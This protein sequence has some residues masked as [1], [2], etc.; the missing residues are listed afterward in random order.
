MICHESDSNVT[1]VTS[2][3]HAEDQE[4]MLIV[5]AFSPTAYVK[6]FTLPVEEDIVASMT[7]EENNSI[8]PVRYFRL[9]PRSLNSF[10]TTSVATPG[11]SVDVSSMTCHARNHPNVEAILAVVSS[12]DDN[13]KNRSCHSD[14]FLPL[15]L[16]QAT[17]SSSPPFDIFQ[18]TQLKLSQ[19]SAHIDPIVQFYKKCNDG[20][21]GSQFPVALYHFDDLLAD[22]SV[23][24]RGVVHAPY[25]ALWTTEVGS[26]FIPHCCYF[27]WG[28]VRVGLRN[29]SKLNIQ[30]KQQK[31]QQQQQQ[32]Q[33]LQQFHKFVFNTVVIDPPWRNKSARRGHK[34]QM[35]FS[36]SDLLALEDN[37]KTV[38]NPGG[39]LVAV[40]VTN[41]NTFQF[42]KQELLPSW[43]IQFVTVWW[44]LKVRPSGAALYEE[45]NHANKCRK[46][47]YERIVI[48]YYGPHV[49]PSPSDT[50]EVYTPFSLDVHSTDDGDGAGDGDGD[51]TGRM[52]RPVLHPT[53]SEQPAGQ[54]SGQMTA[55]AST[56]KRPHS[57]MATVTDTRAT[58]VAKKGKEYRHE[59]TGENPST[60]AYNTWLI[61]AKK[62]KS[63]SL[64]HEIRSHG[65]FSSSYQTRP[66]KEDT[67][68]GEECD[69]ASTPT[70]TPG[71]EGGN[72]ARGH[73][74]ADGDRKAPTTM[75]HFCFPIH[76]ITSVPIRH[77]W[78][79]PL[80]ILLQLS[81][82][83]I[84]HWY[85]PSSSCSPP[86][87]DVPEADPTLHTKD[88]EMN[89]TA[90]RVDLSPEGLC[91][92][93]LELFAR[94][95]SHYSCFCVLYSPHAWSLYE[96]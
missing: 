22:T 19:L 42:V 41:N 71:C 20:K 46:K 84:H 13:T 27:F 14:H 51:C 38:L 96:L 56:L 82:Q 9:P 73:G 33:Q 58:V 6:N 53:S 74:V 95:I 93:D 75:E 2:V 25:A 10:T 48:G 83:A 76:V 32:Q 12:P 30:M 90:S 45:G 43:G 26:Y 57:A 36:N 79:P 49:L 5:H 62:F 35:G 24:K 72:E 3:C 55:Q 80:Q 88:Q 16:Q 39:C 50:S 91:G 86:R 92:G 59:T 67:A 70:R 61:D 78:K 68:G 47:T 60:R 29:L 15:L 23:C 7:G 66:T 44:W 87:R 1:N 52:D 34:Y 21:K 18:I 54:P 63:F 31:P 28:D 40:W 4:N 69:T 11:F 85:S 77:S 89:S 64:L 65:F 94:Y 8:H 81:L 37:L 17:D